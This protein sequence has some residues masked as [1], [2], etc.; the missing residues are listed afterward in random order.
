MKY[1]KIKKYFNDFYLNVDKINKIYV[2]QYGN[3]KGIPIFELHGGP[4]GAYHNNKITKY[5]NLKK[6]HLIVIDQRGCGNSIPSC[7]IDKNTTNNMINDIKKVKNH[8]NIKKFIICGFSWGALLTLLYTIKYPKDIISYVCGSGSYFFEK[9]IFPKI[10]FNIYPE[11]W[12]NLCK[13]I[14]IPNKKIENPTFSLQKEVCKKYF[15]KIK[16]SKVGNKYTKEWFHFESD[17]VIICEKKKE[18]SKYPRKKMYELSLYE[19]YYYYKNFFT[20]NKYIIDNLHKIKHIKGYIIHGRIDVICGVKESI[21]LHKLLPK[22]KLFIID[23]NSHGG[24]EI[25]DVFM[26][27]LQKI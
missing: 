11:R 14:G 2:R 22:S 23:N 18:R 24:K 12:Y 6:F 26:K 8:L 19:S 17:L 16:N 21:K 15:N 7:T 3:K 27:I 20:S 9:N 25:N 10:V 5:F 4:G 13:L 1:Y